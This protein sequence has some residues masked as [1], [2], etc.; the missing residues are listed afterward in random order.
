MTSATPD[1]LELLLKLQ[2]KDNQILALHHEVKQLP[3]REEI[4]SIQTQQEE[5]QKQIQH[6]EMELHVN[7][8]NQKR[9]EDEVAT[10][11]D[12][13]Q[14]QQNKLYGGQVQAIKELQALEVDI[15]GLKER[16]LLVEDQ[17]IEVMELNEPIFQEID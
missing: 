5:L 15:D 6:V 13:M 8:R 12:R 3:E 9:L 1:N 17:I 10:I 7:Q 14:G 4:K 16:Q 11:E 2:D